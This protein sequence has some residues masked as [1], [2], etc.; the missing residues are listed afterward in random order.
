MHL[1]ACQHIPVFS[2]PIILRL[3]PPDPTVAALDTE[4]PAG[5]SN[6]DGSLRQLCFHQT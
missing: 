6:A 1:H 2:T 4:E 3:R 5:G